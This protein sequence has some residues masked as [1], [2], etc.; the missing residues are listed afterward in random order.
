MIE[1]LDFLSS[2]LQIVESGDP[3]IDSLLK[4]IAPVSGAPKVSLLLINVTVL[5]SGLASFISSLKINLMCMIVMSPGSQ[6]ESSFYLTCFYQRGWRKMVHFTKLETLL[7][8]N[9]AA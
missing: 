6:S 4:Q 5:Y 2:K 3:E 1:N 7:S 8:A 9:G